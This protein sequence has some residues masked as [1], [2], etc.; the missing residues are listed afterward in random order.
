M[1]NGELYEDF[2]GGSELLVD[3]EPY[4]LKFQGPKDMSASEIFFDNPQNIIL[5]TILLLA[6]LAL[7]AAYLLHKRA[8]KKK[9]IANQLAYK[10]ALKSCQDEALNLIKSSGFKE[11]KSIHV[12]TS[13]YFVLDKT[14][15]VIIDRY[16][17]QVLLAD[18]VEGRLGVFPFSKIVS[19]SIQKDSF[20]KTTGTISGYVGTEYRSYGNRNLIHGSMAGQMDT[21]AM[22]NLLQVHVKLDDI[23]GSLFVLNLLNVEMPISSQTYRYILNFAHEVEATLNAI[24]SANSA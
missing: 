1:A 21:Q 20:A 9:F 4:S 18:Y 3:T 17:K 24:A 5:V 14:H 6:T 22:A 10:T 15:E 8:K 12:Q 19:C 2:F 11:T 23:Y 16:S 13:N 7:I